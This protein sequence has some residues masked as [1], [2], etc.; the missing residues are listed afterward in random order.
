M[1]TAAKLMSAIALALVALIASE[2]VKPLLPEGTAFGYFSYA[3]AAIA[4]IVGWKLIG[5]RA[6]RGVMSAIN[7]GLTGMLSMVLIVLFAHA[8]RIMFFNS[9]KL[10]YDS[11]AEAVQDI[12]QMMAE[13][14]VLLFHFN[15][16]FTLIGGALFSGL[17]AE[18]TSRRWR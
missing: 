11:T 4:A 1:P 12:F 3:N 8:F 13:N 17:A 9:R 15:I 5:G 7:N 14:G 2:Q 6:G 10:R 16:L 18:A